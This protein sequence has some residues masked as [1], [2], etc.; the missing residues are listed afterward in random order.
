MAPECAR[1]DPYN[2][3]ADVYSCALL[4]HELYSLEKPYENIRSD[5]H[6]DL[7][8][9]KGARPSLPK[10]WPQPLRSCLHKAWADNIENRPTMKEFQ[11]MWHQELKSIVLADKQQKYIRRLGR[12]AS[13][14]DFAASITDKVEPSNDM[15]HGHNATDGQ[16]H[17][18]H[19]DDF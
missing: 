3:K 7:V 1:G 15:E 18:H 13:S 6:D 16:S 14:K 9:Y 2:A 10:T 4:L 12:A 17:P 11:S 8:F 19:H 5:E